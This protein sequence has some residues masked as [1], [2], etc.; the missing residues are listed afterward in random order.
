MQGAG[1]T[2]SGGAECSSEGLSFGEYI[3]SPKASGR[4]AWWRFIP[5]P[6][7]GAR[8]GQDTGRFVAYLLLSPSPLHG[9]GPGPT[10][11]QLVGLQLEAQASVRGP[12][13]LCGPDDVLQLQH[14]TGRS[15]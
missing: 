12:A 8:T 15:A 11:H 9:L 7:E 10:F 14:C 4:A 5:V 6:T 3:G 13:G 1:R 2:G